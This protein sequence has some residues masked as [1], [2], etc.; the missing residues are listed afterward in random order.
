MHE[1]DSEFI[2]NGKFLL[3]TES[4]EIFEYN[5]SFYSIS[6]YVGLLSSY[7]ASENLYPYSPESDR[8]TENY[9]LKTFIMKKKSTSVVLKFNVMKMVL[10]VGCKYDYCKDQYLDKYKNVFFYIGYNLDKK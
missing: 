1:V 6:E 5:V 4:G 10:R 7:S 8:D 2:S 3:Y 9:S